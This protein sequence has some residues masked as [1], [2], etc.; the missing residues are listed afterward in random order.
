MSR[1]PSTLARVE[2]GDAHVIPVVVNP[3]DWSSTPLAEL[4]ALPTAAKPISTWRHTEEAYLDVTMGI[5]AAAKALLAQRRGADQARSR[6]AL[7][8]VAVAMVELTVG[9]GDVERRAAALTETSDVVANLLAENGATVDA[10]HPDEI[11]AVFGLPRLHDDDTLRAV[12]AL[13]DLQHRLPAVS[14]PTS[15]NGWRARSRRARR[16]TST[17]C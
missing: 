8:R 4:Q 16:S 12:R 1:S 3:C 7:K 13:A 11:T 14:R 17:C 9:Q 10:L 2:A 15:G 6:A 5:R